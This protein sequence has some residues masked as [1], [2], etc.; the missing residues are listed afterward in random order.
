MTKKKIS[1]LIVEDERNTREGLL[2]LL[3][4]DYEVTLAEDGS[5]GI[6][7]LKRHN[8]DILLSDLKMPGADGMEVLEAA[9]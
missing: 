4:S 9:L 6:N 1:I 3:R 5:R 2:K 7:L 8:Y